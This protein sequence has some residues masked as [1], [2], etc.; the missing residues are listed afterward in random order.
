MKLN[1]AACAFVFTLAVGGS[2]VTPPRSRADMREYEQFAFNQAR[3]ERKLVILD[4]HTRF[5][6]RCRGHSPLV[7]N[8]LTEKR[9]SEVAGFLVDYEKAVPLRKKFD[10]QFPS[11]VIF[12]FN[13]REVGRVT[14]ALS[15]E[16]LESELKR[17]VGEVALKIK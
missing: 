17:V 13:K 6:P 15:H 10:V 12:I 14:G 3:L 9:I 1:R 16:Q 11:T 4:F 5:C 8:L 2:L 7:E